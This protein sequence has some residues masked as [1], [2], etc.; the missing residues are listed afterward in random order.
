MPPSRDLARQIKAYRR[1]KRH[2]QN[3]LGFEV[4]N[5][6][7]AAAREFN[8]LQK[9]KTRIGSSDLKIA[10]ITLVLDGI[11]ISR[12]LQDFNKVPGLRVEDWTKP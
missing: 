7:E 9:L 4:L 2:L 11:L 10:A 1:L 3:Y 12:N 8:R 5:F 6:D